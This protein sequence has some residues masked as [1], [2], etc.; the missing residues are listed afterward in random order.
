MGIDTVALF[1]DPDSPEPHVMEA[2]ET[3]HLPGSTPTETYLDMDAVIGAAKTTGADAVHPGY[4][5]LSE[6]AEFARRVAAE[7]MTWIG[8]P[9]EAIEAMGDKISSKQLARDAG[10]PTLESVEI[11]SS[12]EVAARAAEIGFPLLV[13]ASAGGGGKGMRVVGAP[14]DLDAAIAAARREA[15]GAFADETVFLERYLAAPRH[16]EIQVFA[17]QHGNTVSLFERE[18]SIQRRHQKIIEESPSPAVDDELR[19][20]MGDAAIRVARLVGYVGAGTVE[21]L[22]GDGEFFFLEMNTRL[23]VEHP[24]TEEVTGL[25]LV[26][27]QIEVADGM[28]LAGDALNP[29]LHGHAVEA[30]LY[31]EDP[32]NDFLPVTG[33]VHQFEFATQSWLRVDSGVGSGS[34]I[35]VHYDP[36][37]AKVIA[38]GA[39]RQEATSR[40]AAAL[41][42][43]H[44]HIPITNRSLL[45][46]LLE[47]D[48]FRAGE[49]HTQ[50]LDDADLSQ[51]AAPLA[52]PE[53]EELSAVAAALADQ[54][55]RRAFAKTLS[56]IP[57][58]WRNSPSQLQRAAFRGR[59]GEHHVEY[60]VTAGIAAVDN[61]EVR[62]ADATPDRVVLEAGN[63]TVS[64][65]VA[66]YGDQRFVD[67]PL[68]PAYLEVLPRY[69]SSVT[70][71]SAGSLRAP[72]P[73]KV[74]RVDVVEGD[75]VEEGQVLLVMEA[76]KMEHT[77]RSPLGGT[78]TEV[79]CASGDQVEA[80]SVLIVVT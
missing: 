70:P 25:D 79:L 10:V 6:N 59:H 78:V 39:T 56:T 16:I 5:F 24:V 29:A 66:R 63:E 38:S 2:D 44:V 13:K 34:R 60:D 41:R 8:P 4:G 72:M 69:P 74:I 9:P 71:E 12:D 45:V 47:S 14:E 61:T 32:A 53:I 52:T 31:A 68:A 36:M 42:E 22:Y 76:M 51:L 11:S 30:R 54:A 77:V 55:Q 64:F 3:F 46:R 65:D 73:G 26:R 17:D 21:F 43:A 27:L 7:G 1:S 19:E 57:S 20:A 37:L 62:V 48:R 33:V 75:E 40:L 50:F 58:G 80:D 67:S 15:K 23:Q 49:I 18:C 35:S 28:P